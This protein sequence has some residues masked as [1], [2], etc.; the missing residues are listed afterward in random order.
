[1]FLIPS[2]YR[3]VADNAARLSA[4]R[5][6]LENQL[7]RHLDRSV[8]AY[9]GADVRVRSVDVIRRNRGSSYS[10]SVVQAGVQREVILVGLEVYVVEG[11]TG[12]RSELE[13]DGLVNREI[14][15]DREI[16]EVRMRHADVVHH[17]RGVA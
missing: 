15:K 4:S 14:F 2:E 5:A 16:E 13:T 7:E 3:T 11:A 1:M 6:V 12:F 9:V 8:A 10:G 17:S